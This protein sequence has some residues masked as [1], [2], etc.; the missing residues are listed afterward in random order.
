MKKLLLASI[1]FLVLALAGA[2]HAWTVKKSPPPTITY[3]VTLYGGDGA[4]IKQWTTQNLTS[5]GP[6]VE[7]TDLATRHR[8]RLDG[9]FVVEADGDAII[10]TETDAEDQDKD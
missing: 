5:F 1:A 4:E 3:T 2:S 8:I 10:D 6:G 9:T 7:F